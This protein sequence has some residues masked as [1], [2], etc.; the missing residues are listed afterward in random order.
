M[1]YSTFEITHERNALELIKA[2]RKFDGQHN[3]KTRGG[4]E[5][6]AWCDLGVEVLLSVICFS[7]RAGSSFFCVGVFLGQVS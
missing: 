2:K 3:E 7:L 6:Q 1:Y 4:A 5:L